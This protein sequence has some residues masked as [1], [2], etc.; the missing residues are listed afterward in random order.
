[1]EVLNI[2]LKFCKEK[3][4]ALRG[5][6]KKKGKSIKTKKARNNFRNTKQNI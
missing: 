1:M 4:M 3:F 5:E 6:E 2:K